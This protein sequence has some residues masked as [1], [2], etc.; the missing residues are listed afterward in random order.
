MDTMLPYL[1]S[2]AKSLDLSQAGE[3]LASPHF[4]HLLKSIT[5]LSYPNLQIKL[6]TNLKLVSQRVWND[7]GDTADSINTLRLSIDGAT[8]Q[9]LEKLRRGLK[10]DRMLDALDFIRDLRRKSKLDS[11][12]VNF[13]IQKDNFR[14]LPQMLELCSFYGLD[15]LQAVRISSHGSYTN[16]Q[17]R[18]I[19]VGDPAHPLHAEYI[20]V[21]KQTVALHKEMKEN[22]SK[23]VASGRSVPDFNPLPV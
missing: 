1:L 9:T 18:D 8:P 6:L 7:L 12:P 2:N 15:R 19:D 22:I 20:A 23:I 17:F 14:E 13:I 10:W 4:R 21:I 5:P 16:D 3:A 11:V